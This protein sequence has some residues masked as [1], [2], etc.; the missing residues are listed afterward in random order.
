MSGYTDPKSIR[1]FVASELKANASESSLIGNADDAA[2]LAASYEHDAKTLRNHPKAKQWAALAK[3]IRQS[4]GIL[5]RAAKVVARAEGA[6]SKAKNPAATKARALYKKLHWGHEGAGEEL[7]VHAPEP[8]SGAAV[9]LGE[10][11]EVVYRTV[12][13]KRGKVT[14]FAHD[15]GPKRHVFSKDRPLLVFVDGKRG[16]LVIAGGAYRVREEGIVG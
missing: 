4:E 14:D 3:K 11:V 15:F 10:L 16:G 1:A 8:D 5:R 12:K 2:R 7:R 6:P 9:V 13:G